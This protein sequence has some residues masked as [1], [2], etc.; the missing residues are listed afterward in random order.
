MDR[1]EVEE[2]RLSCPGKY[3]ACLSSC[4]SC[5]L[6]YPPANAPSTDTTHLHP[7]PAVSLS[8]LSCTP[9]SY[10]LLF[11]ISVFSNPPRSF[12]SFTLN[13][14]MHPYVFFPT[15]LSYT[16]FFHS[17][18]F[19]SD[20]HIFL[21]FTFSS[22][23]LSPHRTH[24]SLFP[25]SIPRIFFSVILPLSDFP[26]Q[27]SVLTDFLHHVC[28]SSVILL[29]LSPYFLLLI[30]HPPLPYLFPSSCFSY[31]FLL[32]SFFLSDTHFF[33]F[34]VSLSLFSLSPPL[35]SPFIPAFPLTLSSNS[36]TFPLPSTVFSTPSSSG[37]THKPK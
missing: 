13:S 2:L 29:T 25:L 12:L 1:V 35:L 31:L 15:S 34:L 23:H 18:P 16:S 14:H 37:Q 36:S 32:S 20:F 27:L 10:R 5:P 11:L 22:L 21:S 33:F 9:H 3:Q 8:H 6:P 4:L 28:V 7:P 19:I 26:R 17:S 30:F 24:V